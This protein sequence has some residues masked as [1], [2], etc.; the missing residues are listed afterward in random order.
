M[1]ISTKINLWKP[2]SFNLLVVTK[3]GV[4]A[5]FVTLSIALAIEP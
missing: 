5:F 4:Y 1:L 2:K 3:L